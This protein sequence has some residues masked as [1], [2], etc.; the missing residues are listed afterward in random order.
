V[1]DLTGSSPPAAPTPPRR[2]TRPPLPEVI[3]VDA[4]PDDDPRYLFARPASRRRFMGRDYPAPALPE[5][6]HLFEMLQPGPRQ[7][8]ILGHGG[9]IGQ[10]GPDMGPNEVFYNQLDGAAGAAAG[11]A[12][13][14]G[15]G[16]G[17]TGAGNHPERAAG[18][19]AGVPGGPN[20]LPDGLWAALGGRDRFQA[21]PRNG[22]HAPDMDYTVQA[23]GIFRRQRDT[24]PVDAAAL[25][26]VDYKTPA[27]A[28]SGFTRSP[29]DT[30][31]LVCVHCDQE[32]GIEIDD[33]AMRKAG[34]VWAGKCGHVCLFPPGLSARTC[35][36]TIAQCYCGTCA[37][38]FHRTPP[39]G[40]KR[41]RK[42]VRKICVV[43][44]CSTN[45]G[46]KT[47]MIKIHL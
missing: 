27:P 12:A 25:R 3:D 19:R 40:S 13:A 35:L 41:S 1:I 20:R 22:F 46:A 34:E 26:N 30:D 18:R 45:L 43:E 14:A 32:L 17:G 44:N 8:P 28:Q 39:P 11:A 31:V 15:R 47:G 2:P 38:I 4:L 36:L 9:R 33:P 23:P 29:K 5:E 37:H 10:R 21:F 16:P 42:S 6:P 24:P 7:D